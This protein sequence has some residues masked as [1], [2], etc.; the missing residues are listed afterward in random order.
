MS[1]L[2]ISIPVTVQQLHYINSIV[3]LTSLWG[4]KPR[5]SNHLEHPS[6]HTASIQ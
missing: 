6:N 4:N 3:A 5:P 2:N 1:H